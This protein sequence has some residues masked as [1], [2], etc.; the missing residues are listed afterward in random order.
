MTRW[1]GPPRCSRSSRGS[2]G[3]KAGLKAGDVLTRVDGR[4]VG[5][6]PEFRA[7]LRPNADLTLTVTRDGK[8]VE[9][10]LHVSRPKSDE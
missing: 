8:D 4:R 9:L 7:L 2:A 10:T 1:G 5:S 6:W 3:A